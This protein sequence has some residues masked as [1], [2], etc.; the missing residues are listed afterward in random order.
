MSGSRA[1]LANGV[2]LRGLGT[3]ATLI[4]VNGRRMAGSGLQG[5][6]SDASALPA[7][8]VERVDVLLDGASALY[9]S[10]AVGGVVNVI[11]RRGFDGQETRAR[12]S[13]FDGGHDWSLAHTLGRRW[14]SG[15][16]LL[17]YET[18]RSAAL[19]ADDRVYTRTGDLRPFGGSDRRQFYAAPGNIMGINAAGT[20]YEAL[21]AI[22]PQADGTAVFAAGETNLAFRQAG[23]DI[24]PEQEVHSGYAH[25]D[26]NPAPW[27]RL[28][29]D[30]RLNDRSFAYRSLSPAGI[31]TVT[32]ANP[33]FQSPTG[34]ASHQVAYNFLDEAGPSWARGASVT[35]A[36]QA[37]DVAGRQG[38]PADLRARFSASW[39]GTVM[40]AVAAINHVAAYHDAAGDRIDAWTTLDLQLGWSPPSGVLEGLRVSFGVR[41][42][43]DQD[44]PFF[45]APSGFGFDPGQADPYGRT[46]YLQLIKR[47]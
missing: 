9:G 4:L 21:W 30:F 40:D 34:A 42:L 1:R 44:P 47:W 26:L 20:G 15:S 35:P 14:S 45:N 43:L 36:A 32:A 46:G 22:R 16:A 11:L 37:D 17:S 18:R 33:Y 31:A 12:V 38:F 25:V 27:L 8:A 2:N 5:D 6:F 24:L 13:G 7:A 19:N 23:I 28:S 39:S 10:D 3:D 29:A 41:N